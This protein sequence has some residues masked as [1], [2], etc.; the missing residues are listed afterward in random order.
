LT[1]ITEFPPNYDEIVRAFPAVAGLKPFF[2][3]GE[4][5]YNPHGEI[6]N[7][8]LR[9]HEARH[10]VQHAAEGGPD[11]WWR[12]YID[13]PEFRLDMEVEAYRVQLASYAATTRDREKRHVYCMAIAGQ[14]S[15]AMYGNLTTRL[16]AYRRL[17]R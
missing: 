6:I 7:V 9:A 14:L 1:V 11:A 10:G 12:R 16:D 3:W 5:I 8:H 15:S 13:D 17:S 2:S 4:D